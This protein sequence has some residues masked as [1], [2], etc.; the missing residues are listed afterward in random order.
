MKKVYA[1]KISF[2]M[3]VINGEPFIKYNLANLYPHA[4]EIL[5]VEGA[6]EKY[7][8]AA[9]IDG[10]SL[11]DT[12]KIIKEFP[13]PD[14]KIKL[15]Q[16]DG[17]WPEK[18]E[19][20]NAYME[21]CTGDYIWQIDVDEFYHPEDIEKVRQFLT[22]NPDVTRI[23]VQTI[24]FWHSFRAIM[25]GATYCFGADQ[26]R[27]IFK[28]NLGY[29]FRTHRPP[30]VI[31][32]DG[33]V[34][35]DGKVVTAEELVNKLNVYMYH[36][37]YVFKDYVHG[38]AEYYSKMNWR[39]GH[40]D[41]STWA[42]D[43]WNNLSNP[44]RIH[45][46]NYPPSW[47]IPFE[48]NHP[49]IIYKLINEITYKEDTNIVNFLMKDYLKYKKIGENIVHLILSYKNGSISKIGAALRTLFNIDFYSLPKI[50]KANN[51]I[52]MVALRFIRGQ[53]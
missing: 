22:D 6:V 42:N 26:F 41:G 4:H 43:E 29:R 36:Y 44:L 15:I 30:T 20:S 18:D 11:D 46:I 40:E 31:D 45:I 5:I 3:I 23:D 52:L 33:T 17:F 50:T 38:K 34:C 16:C 27:R 53:V 24:N 10:H 48:G 28:F 14:N 39:N 12:V 51:T 2:G 49:E 37:S 25:Q 9:T 7:K 13:D 47:I 32:S 8:H 19:M 1:L 35:C 21:K